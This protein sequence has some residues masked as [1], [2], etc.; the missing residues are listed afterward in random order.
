VW[1]TSELKRLGLPRSHQSHLLVLSSATTNS[2][3]YRAEVRRCRMSFARL[4]QIRELRELRGSPGGMT[5]AMGCIE[6]PL[7][8]PAC[9][10]AIG[11]T[12]RRTDGI[13]S[14]MSDQG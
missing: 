2:S 11:L 7:G 4:G 6:F 1:Q 5:S 10:L 3:R 13:T 12:E 9:Y 14:N 8:R